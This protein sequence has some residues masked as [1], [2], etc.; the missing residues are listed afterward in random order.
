MEQLQAVR[1]TIFVELYFSKYSDEKDVRICLLHGN[2]RF[3][4][5]L[6]EV[7]HN[8]I[9]MCETLTDEQLHNLV[10]GIY[11]MNFIEHYA[12]AGSWLSCSKPV[13]KAMNFELPLSGTRPAKVS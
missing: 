12:L 9:S 8:P 7:D 4:E 5:L 13:I 2:R 10:D 1:K 6:E 3:Y 11:Y